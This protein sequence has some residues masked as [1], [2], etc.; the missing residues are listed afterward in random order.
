MIPS[1]IGLIL[2][3]TDVKLLPEAEKWINKAIETNRRNGNRLSLA[4]DYV[5]YADLLQRKGNLL[6]AKAMLS[7]AVEINQKCGADGWVDKYE[8]DLAAL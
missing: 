8:K 3:N 5:L 1:N 7:K 4:G 2:M 6:D